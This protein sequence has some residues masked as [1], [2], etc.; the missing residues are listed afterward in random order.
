MHLDALAR[1]LLQI[2]V[3]VGV[4]QVFTRLGRRIGQPAVVSEIL[5]GI[6]LGPSLLGAL[7]PEAA[8][9]LFPPSSLGGLEAVAQLGLILFMFLVGLELD[10][11]LL[12]RSGRS[13]I[14][15]SQAGIV[16]P[17]GLGLALA[18]Q[19][20]DELSL[21]GVPFLSF[22]LFLGVA[23][24]ITAF[25]VLA[26]LLTERGMVATPLG[27]IVLA[28]AA[29][30]DVTAWCLLAFV[31]SFVR[32]EGASAAFVTVGLAL[33]FALV[34]L[35][36]GRHLM[37]KLAVPDA[38]PSRERFTVVLLLVLASALT[39]EAIGIHALFGA[40]VAGAMLPHEGAFASGLRERLEDLVVVA[41]LPIFFAHSG[42]RT[43]LGLLDS[44]RDLLLCALVVGVA[45][46]GKLGG[47]AIAARIVGHPWREAAT[48]GVLMNTRGLMELVVL[49]VGLDLGVL[50]PKLFTM[51]VVMAIVTTV[52]TGPAVA[53]LGA[54]RRHTA[55]V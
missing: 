2:G 55:P 3:I 4:A 17:F 29:I 43:E 49:H 39:T 50:S 51:M 33:A 54:A 7:W 28:A 34:M 35:T 21:P 19:V 36:L 14:A 31:V 30:D 32:A 24:S 13:A 40:F 53:W 47:V 48:L 10:P 27:S 42:L 44:S 16:V 1:L 22:A 26:R 8:A 20:H 15:L 5:A 41:M 11:A 46:V 25:P 52:A 12:R 45:V 37:K 18:S 6:A 9:F 23:M 38:P